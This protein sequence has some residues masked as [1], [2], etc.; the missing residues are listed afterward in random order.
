M[1]THANILRTSC[2]VIYVKVRCGELKRTVTYPLKWKLSPLRG[3]PKHRLLTQTTA[4][5]KKTSR[6]EQSKTGSSRP[7]VCFLTSEPGQAWKAPGPLPG[8]SA[9]SGA[10][11][12][13]ASVIWTM[14]RA[15]MTGAGSRWAADWSGTN[16]SSADVGQITSHSLHSEI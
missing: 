1:H 12:G 5:H 9:A 2:W 4:F 14:T 6:T 13:Q 11:F 10:P 7:Q 8:P 16:G 15:R 3:N